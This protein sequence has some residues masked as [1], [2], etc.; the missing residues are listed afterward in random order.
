[1]AETITIAEPAVDASPAFTVGQRVRIRGLRGV[2]TVAQRRRYG[3][4]QAWTWEYQ[5][6][7]GTTDDRAGNRYPY[8]VGWQF[9]RFLEAA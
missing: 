6:A 1:M 5:L 2:F 9:E 7:Y 8:L 4:Q 3:G